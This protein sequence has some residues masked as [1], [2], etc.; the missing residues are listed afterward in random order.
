LGTTYSVVS[1]F[2]DND[3]KVIQDELGNKIIPSYVA[4]EN[5]EK[6]LV[7]DM[8]K[9]KIGEKYLAIIYD[10]KRLIGR[11]CDDLNVMKDKQNWPFVIKEDP[12]TKKPK[13]VVKIKK[14]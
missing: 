5:E 6:M 10:V 9:T 1:I 11:K 12:K 4:F 2:Q 13:I 8:A 14:N 3:V 7:G